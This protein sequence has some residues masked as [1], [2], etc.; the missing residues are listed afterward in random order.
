MFQVNSDLPTHILTFI[1][2]VVLGCIGG[3]LGSMFVFL[4]L[5]IARLRRKVLSKTNS[6]TMKKI[7]RFA[8]PCL[9]MVRDLF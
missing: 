4:N 6:D 5:K 1:P 9:I 2:T 8:E 3:V 7:I